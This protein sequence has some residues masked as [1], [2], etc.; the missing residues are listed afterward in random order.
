MKMQWDSVVN[1]GLIIVVSSWLL[2]CLAGVLPYVLY[3]GEF[4]FTNAWFESV[5]GFTTT[6]S[7]ILTDVEALPFGLLFG[8][9]QL[10]G[11]A[12]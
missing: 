11:S 6:G 12:A 9:P 1:E 7:S 2:S 10:I 5:S 4:T 8:A 3:G